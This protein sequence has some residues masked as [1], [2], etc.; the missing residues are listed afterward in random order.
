MITSTGAPTAVPR[1]ERPPTRTAPTVGAPQ[2]QVTAY[3]R[4][5]SSMPAQGHPAA[6]AISGEVLDAR[7]RVPA[8][9]DAPTVGL[10]RP[11]SP[12]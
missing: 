2:P 9:G 4:P 12:A 11:S 6:A 3:D 5:V 10:S 7:R 8:A 1:S